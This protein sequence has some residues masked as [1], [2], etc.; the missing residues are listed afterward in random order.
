MYFTKFSVL[1]LAASIAGVVLAQEEVGT[2]IYFL[3]LI[4]SRARLPMFH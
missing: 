2:A 4:K 3:V 1:A